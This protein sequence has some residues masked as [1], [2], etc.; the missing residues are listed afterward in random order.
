MI[1]LSLTGV[2]VAVIERSG[3]EPIVHT[4]R[5]IITSAGDQYYAER[6]IRQTVPTNFTDGS[7][8]FDGIIE[9]YNSS[10]QPPSKESNRSHLGGLVVA[11]PM[12]EGYPRINDDHPRNTLYS[13]PNIVTYYAFF[14][15]DDGES[16]NIASVIITNPIPKENEPVLMHATFGRPLPKTHDDTLKVFLNHR[17]NGV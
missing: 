12:H 4:T 8:K 16:E 13:A 17:F 7:G 3:C 14:E 15:E 6:A 9:L 5:N 10:K 2:V 11:K 1:D